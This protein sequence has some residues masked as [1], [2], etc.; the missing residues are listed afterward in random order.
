[1]SKRTEKIGSVIKRAISTPINDL[2]KEFNSGITSI[3]EI[4]IS[5]DLQNA[6]IYIS[7]F[8]GKINSL[9]F[10]TIL[11]K[12]KF[13][14]KAALSRDAFL[15]YIPELKFFIDDSMEKMGQIQKVLDKISI[16]NK[17]LEEQNAENNQDITKDDTTESTESS[18]S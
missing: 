13:K 17:I 1:M 5:P 14:I 6:K 3:N 11:E 7:C 4:V 12:N 16:N 2:A 10:V 9:Q 8:G 18:D 15:K